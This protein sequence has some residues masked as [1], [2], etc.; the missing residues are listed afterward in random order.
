MAE[1]LYEHRY[2]NNLNF[3]K[4]AKKA[5]GITTSIKDIKQYFK[6]IAEKEK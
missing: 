4:D 2:Q 5:R 1:E 6:E 3:F